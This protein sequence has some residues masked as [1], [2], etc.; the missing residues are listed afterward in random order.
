MR[1]S[2][3]VIPCIPQFPSFLSW[4]RLAALRLGLAAGGAVLDVHQP[5]GWLLPLPLPF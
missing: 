4:L 1:P 3:A 2:S 5:A